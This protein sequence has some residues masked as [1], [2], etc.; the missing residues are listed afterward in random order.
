VARSLDHQFAAPRWRMMERLHA[1]MAKRTI[2]IADA[3]AVMA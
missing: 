3:I 2:M 1:N